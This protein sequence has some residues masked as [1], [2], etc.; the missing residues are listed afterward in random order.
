MIINLGRP[1][2]SRSCQRMC[3]ACDGRHLARGRSK[4]VLRHVS[5][6][7]QLKCSRLQST[8]ES[9]AAL[10]LRASSRNPGLDAQARK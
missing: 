2:H 3:D 9:F 4:P 1:N 8:I 6:S 10:P 5:D 7:S